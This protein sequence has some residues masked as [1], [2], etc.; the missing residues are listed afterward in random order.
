LSRIVAIYP[1]G[2]ALVRGRR[3]DLLDAD[4]VLPRDVEVVLVEEAIAR[5]EAEM[6]QMH[7]VRVVGEAHPTRVGN[8]IALAVDHELVEVG[9]RPA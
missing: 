3:H 8:A 4:L 9:V 6:S 2:I 1:D 7:L 5:P